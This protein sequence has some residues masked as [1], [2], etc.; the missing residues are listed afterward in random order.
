M[1]GLVWYV[2]YGS[3]LSAGRFSCYL[4]GGRPPGG[5]LSHPGARDR[6][7]PRASKA[8]WIPGGVYF[9]TPSQVWGGGRALYDPDAPGRAAA[10]AYLITAQQFSDV[11]AQEMYREPGADLDLT[12]VVAAGRAQLGPG[13]YETLICAGRDGRVP[14]VTFTAPWGMADVPLLRPGARYLRTLGQGLGQ[15]HGWDPRQTAG[16]LSG[17]PGARGSWTAGEIAAL[18]AGGTAAAHEEPAHAER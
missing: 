4:R 12:E 5:A 14:M 10:R 13:R 18:L 3:N 17:L 15:A 7:L 8:A 2:A 9:A 16:Y 1:S 6:S 11:A